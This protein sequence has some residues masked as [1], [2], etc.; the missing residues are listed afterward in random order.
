M[1]HETAELLAP[2]PTTAGVHLIATA[3]EFRGNTRLVQGD[4]IALLPALPPG[5]RLV[6]FRVFVD[7]LGGEGWL[8][9]LRGAHRALV[10]LKAL[11]SISAG[12]VI[13]PSS[14]NHI[15]ETGPVSLS[16]ASAPHMQYLAGKRIAA[17]FTI[18]L[19]A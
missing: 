7:P 11:A 3:F 19:E 4:R 18:A 10:P 15:G 14:P 17:V 1:A 5:G 12:G 9:E 8:V 16:I 6:D 13:E 2:L